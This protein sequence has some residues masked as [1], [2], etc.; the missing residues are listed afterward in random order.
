MKV[1]GLF[2]IEVKAGDRRT[3]MSVSCTC[4][5]LSESAKIVSL[6]IQC[7]DSV[8]NFVKKPVR[9]LSVQILPVSTLSGL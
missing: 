4:L 1:I 6:S 8:R 3:A 5:V 7:P 2:C 9:R